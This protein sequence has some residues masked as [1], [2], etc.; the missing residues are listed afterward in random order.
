MIIFHN[1]LDQQTPDILMDFEARQYI[2]YDGSLYGSKTEAEEAMTPPVST[3]IYFYNSDEW[4]NVFTTVTDENDNPILTDSQANQEMN[5]IWWYMEVDLDTSASPVNV[6]FSNGQ[7]ETTQLVRID[8]LTNVFMTVNGDLFESKEDAEASLISSDTTTIYFYNSQGWT[9]VY[10]YVFSDYGEVLG[11]WNE[12]QLATQDT[13]DSGW[14]MV[15]VPLDA[16]LQAFNIIFSNQDRSIQ[17]GEVLIDDIESVYVAITGYAFSSKQLVIDSLLASTTLYFYNSQG[18]SEVHA[19]VFGD[20]GELLGSWEE[21]QAA[22]QDTEDL[23]WWL[24]DVPV[25]TVNTPIYIIFHNNNNGSQTQ[26]YFIDNATNIYLVPS[27]GKYTDKASAESNLETTTRVYFYNPI[28]VDWDV[29][30]HMWE[31][32]GTNPDLDTN[33]PGT[34]LTQWFI[35]DDN[36]DQTAEIATDWWYIDVSTTTSSLMLVL[37]DNGGVQ[38]KDILIYAYD[39]VFIELDMLDTVDGK[40]TVNMAFSFENIGAATPIE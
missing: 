20:A 32:N 6:S 35:D 11:A 4:E 7:V 24:I 30:A 26:N 15:D 9:S 28:E 13:N 1:N 36:D 14:W 38:T 19:Y 10:A 22:T 8:D 21:S 29:K 40:Y 34:S 16:S 33:W 27:G 17:S 3:T 18:W 39:E 2:T 5:S 37:S 25:D 23:G 12:S 31:Y